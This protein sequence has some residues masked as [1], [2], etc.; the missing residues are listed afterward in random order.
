MWTL[1][2][3][4]ANKLGEHFED[5]DDVIIAKLDATANEFEDV[6]VQGFPTNKYWASI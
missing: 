2:G 4:W 3:T 5:S 6:D 1:Q